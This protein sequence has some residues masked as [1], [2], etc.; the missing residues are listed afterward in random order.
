MAAARQKRALEGDHPSELRIG[1]ALAAGIVR[2]NLKE[3][4]GKLRRPV[5]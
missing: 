2:L 5:H 4:E 3:P 1:D